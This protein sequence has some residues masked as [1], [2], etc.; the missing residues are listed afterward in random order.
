MLRKGK[1]N[2]QSR[3]GLSLPEF[4]FGTE[5]AAEKRRLGNNMAGLSIEKWRVLEYDKLYYGSVA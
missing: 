5:A 1:Q 2:N 3:Q 4:F